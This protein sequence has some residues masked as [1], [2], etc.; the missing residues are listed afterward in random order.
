MAQTLGSVAVGSIVKLNENG[1]PANYIVVHQGL[2]SA[3]Y[4]A[5]CNGTWLLR[6]DI[7][8]NRVWEPYNVN[9]IENSYIRSYLDETW[10]NCYDTKIRNAIKKVTIPI[11][12]DGGAGG[13]DLNDGT[14]GMPCKVFLL[15]CRETGCGNIDNPNFPND[16]AK[17]DYFIDGL[18]TTA[19]NKRIATLDGSPANWML[20]SPDCGS[21]NYVWNVFHNGYFGHETAQDASGVR[22]ALILPS[23]LFVSN[24]GKVVF[25]NSPSQLTGP[26]QAM[27]GNQ[28]TVSWTAVDGADGYILERKANTDTDW[29]Q[30]YSG[31]ATTFSETVG[32][33]TSVQYRVCAVFGSTDSG[34]TE[35]ASIPVVPAS[36]L[37][38]FGSDGDLGTLVN[39]VQYT[40]STDTGNPITAT[41]TVGGIEIFSGTV[42]SGAAGIIPVVDIPT[43][44]GTISISAS[45]QATNGA[46][47]AT[48]NWTYTKA[49][50]TF[51]DAGSVADL[52]QNGKTIL[53]KTI[54]EAVRAPGV[55]GGNLGLAL[56]TLAKA[57]LYDP[58]T[59]GFEG[60]GGADAAI[61]VP[62]IET[63]SYVG[64]G[65]YGSDNPTS[66]TVGFTPMLVFVSQNDDGA[67]D[68]S[69]GWIRGNISGTLWL[70]SDTE[71]ATLSWGVNSVSFY[72][73]SAAAQFNHSGIEY[74]YCII[75]LAG[76]ESA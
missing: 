24:D 53:A 12:E 63:G 70:G 76:G 21:T 1:S 43:S 38:I 55:W 45:V 49:A 36:A 41:V 66:I 20:R 44:V 31:T 52:I 35:S 48:R 14:S 10:I 18:D 56:Q 29:T 64:T 71:Y 30:V 34:W 13:T 33:W 50:I 27:Q 42:E 57:V 4:N 5:N 37:V 68:V 2:P 61:P 25:L 32:T 46:V 15:S 17:L 8:E 26:I 69:G 54:A 7:A 39:D 59:G 72:G 3:T 40:I 19:T 58:E 65:T 23:D 67:I 73:D 47:S 75:G 74:N 6:Q 62:R 28:I 9:V 51:P 11:R 16:G 22:P 60:I